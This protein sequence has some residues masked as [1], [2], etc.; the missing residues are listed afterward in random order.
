MQ[1]KAEGLAV[2]PAVHKFGI[3][4]KLF[5]EGLLKSLLFIS[6]QSTKT[7]TEAFGKSGTIE[8]IKTFRK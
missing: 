8:R 5:A 3:V 6:T 1:K 2:L 4:V 7:I